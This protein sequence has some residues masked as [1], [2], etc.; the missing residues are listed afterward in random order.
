GPRD[1][2]IR[3]PAPLGDEEPAVVVSGLTSIVPLDHPRY[4]RL[5]VRAVPGSLTRGQRVYLDLVHMAPTGSITVEALH[6]DGQPVHEGPPVEEVSEASS[7]LITWREQLE[8]AASDVD[9]VVR[10]EEAPRSGGTL[11]AAHAEALASLPARA[12][13][14]LLGSAL[15]CGLLPGEF[16]LASG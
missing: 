4:G 12:R 10:E 16:N 7:R 11:E 1:L 15:A 5:T 3:S 8:C 9:H 13:T 14:A 6:L 2:N